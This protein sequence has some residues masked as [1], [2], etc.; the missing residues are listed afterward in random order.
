MGALLYQYKTPAFQYNHYS[1]KI[2]DHDLLYLKVT[3]VLKKDP[4]QFKYIVEVIS[5]H[6]MPSSGKLLLNIKR[7]TTT[8]ELNVDNL[9]IVNSSIKKIY[10]LATHINLSINGKSIV[11]IDGLW[12]IFRIAA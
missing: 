1:K 7:D 6:N 5:V 12:N 10:Q 8:T 3:E 11:F 9:L 2:T 4:Y